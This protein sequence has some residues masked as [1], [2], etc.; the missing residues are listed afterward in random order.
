MMMTP[1]PGQ[2]GGV[3]SNPTPIVGNVPSVAAGGS[4]GLPMVTP[5]MTPMT[6]GSAA[7]SVSGVLGKRDGGQSESEVEEGK[8]KKRRV[9]PTLVEGGSG[10]L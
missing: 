6:G 8:R 7:S 2:M 10:M 3:A 1:T 5:P 9:A 4:T